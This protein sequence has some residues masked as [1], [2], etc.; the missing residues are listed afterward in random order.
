MDPFQPSLSKNENLEDFTR[1]DRPIHLHEIGGCEL[2]ANCVPGQRVA[3]RLRGRPQGL[4]ALESAR[5][6]VDIYRALGR[7]PKAD[8]TD[9]V[10]MK[11]IDDILAATKAAGKRCAIYCKSVEYSKQMIAKG[12]DFVVVDPDAIWKKEWG[13]LYRWT[14]DD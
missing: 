4:D 11:A 6:Q 9:P 12:F 7:E 3:E 10:V 14:G 5:L 2:N 13:E 8:Q 1:F